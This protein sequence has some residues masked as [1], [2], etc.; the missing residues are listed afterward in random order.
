MPFLKTLRLGIE[1]TPYSEARPGLWSTFTLTISAARCFPGQFLQDWS[2]PLARSAP[3]GVE[4]DENGYVRLQDHIIE[5]GIVG[6]L[7]LRLCV[8]DGHVLFSKQRF[9]CRGFLAWLRPPIVAG[10]GPRTTHIAATTSKVA[11]GVVHFQADE[12]CTA[13]PYG[14]WYA[15]HGST[16]SDA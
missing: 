5:V 4:I 13:T 12:D 16:R 2:E 8:R 3:I 10:I 9:R 7:D 14:S 1:S 15:M 6:M 11:A